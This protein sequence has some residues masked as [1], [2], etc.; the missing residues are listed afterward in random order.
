MRKN[1]RAGPREGGRDGV[2]GRKHCGPVVQHAVQRQ[3]ER[4]GGQS[5][6]GTSSIRLEGM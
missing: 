2:I 4:G 6:E 5:V 3:G 1:A